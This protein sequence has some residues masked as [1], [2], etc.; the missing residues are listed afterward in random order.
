MRSQSKLLFSLVLWSLASFA[1]LSASGC[2]KNAGT[3]ATP[4]AVSQNAPS[5]NEI[6]NS[7]S[8]NAASGTAPS[9]D[10]VIAGKIELAPL[11]ERTTI[12]ASAAIYLIARPA[13]QAGGPPVA[14][15]Q[16]TQP[17]HFPIA[18]SLSK[19]DAMMPDT[20]FQGSF[21]VTARLAQSGSA[22]PAAAGDFEGFV[23]SGAV[24]VGQ[25]NV[26]VRLS[27]VRP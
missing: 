15:K 18:F 25:K 21:D 13:G 1:L 26:E 22:I 7:V 3:S 5:S 23:E 2:T 17:F 14:V 20:P 9:S 16:F 12:Q 6:G 4:S 10:A 24:Q 11:L 27:K 8:G 19:A